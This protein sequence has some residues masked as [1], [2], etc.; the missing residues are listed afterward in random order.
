MIEF[1]QEIITET[2]PDGTQNIK[3]NGYHN[4]LNSVSTQTRLNIPI[5]R[6]TILTELVKCLDLMKTDTPEIIIRLTKDKTGEPILLQKT[7]VT[8]KEKLK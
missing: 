5:S 4:G 8:Y 7:W 6:N 1:G 2:N 3:T